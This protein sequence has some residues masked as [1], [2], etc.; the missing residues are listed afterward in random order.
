M[1]CAGDTV[2]SVVQ[3]DGPALQGL[4][5]ASSS[6]IAADVSSTDDRR[7]AIT[8]DDVRSDSDM[9]ID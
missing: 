7:E 9:D 3:N 4:E 5:E 8:E 1:C 6:G 2:E